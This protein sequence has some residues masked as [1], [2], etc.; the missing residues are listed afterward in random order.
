MRRRLLALAVLTVISAL[1]ARAGV[2]YVPV[3]PLEGVQSLEVQAA[4]RDSSIARR[5]RARLLPLAS[6]GT[7]GRA[8]LPLTSLSVGARAVRTVA[9]DPPAEAG[10]LELVSPPQLSFSAHLVPA[11]LPSVAVPVPVITSKNLVAAGEVV[12][13]VGLARSADG[14]ATGVGIVNLGHG[15]AT[16][17]GSLAAANGAAV[18]RAVTLSVLALSHVYVTDAIAALGAGETADAVLSISCDQAFFPYAVLTHASAG[19]MR[20]FTPAARGDSALELPGTTPPIPPGAVLFTRSGSFHTATEAKPTEVFN[21]PVPAGMAFR[22]ITLS[23]DYYHAGWS[24]TPDGNHSLFWLHRGVWLDSR[25]ADN[26]YAFVNA[27]GPG[28]NLVKLLTNVDAGKAR[29][30]WQATYGLEAGHTYRV[31]YRYDGVAQVVSVRLTDKASGLQVVDIVGDTYGKP[32]VSDASG[33]FFVYFG[34]QDDTG[35][36]PE[37]PSYGSVWSALE[38]LFQP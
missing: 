9:I 21:I 11:A 3:P 1:P 23:F 26:I 28:K 12:E 27:F 29:Q 36:A 33:S 7:T 17:S 4:N 38:V 34:H 15:S 35:I 14:I 37:R 20:V 31:E 16:C 10:L 22:Q 6:D 8:G 24:H 5:F 30:V 18:G 19:A 32:I 25:W 13:L 2:L